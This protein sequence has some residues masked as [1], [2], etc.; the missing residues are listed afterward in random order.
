L[1]ST[2]AVTVLYSFTGGSDG[3]GPNFSTLVRDPAG[4]LYGTTSY[5]GDPGAGTVFKLDTKGKETVLYNFTGG[6]DGSVPFS[7]LLR[8]TAGNL[9]GLTFEGGDPTCNCGTVFELTH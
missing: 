3:Y 2:N 4:N 5:G 6:T 8:D 9:Y 1:N 7:G